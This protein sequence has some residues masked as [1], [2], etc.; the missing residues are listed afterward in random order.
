MHE[1]AS[2]IH[3]I[4]RL[5][6][7]QSI[8]YRDLAES[9]T[10]SE[11]SVKRMMSANRITLDRLSQISEILGYT[12]SE[13]TQEA[14][15]SKARISMLTVEQERLIVSDTKLLLTTVCALNHWKLAEIVETYQLSEAE[16]LQKLLILDRLQILDLLPENRIRLLIARDFEWRKHGPISEFFR[17]HAQPDFLKD[18]FTD[19]DAM[20]F[21]HG[22][23]T[24]TAYSELQPEIDRLR[25][26]FTEFHDRSLPASRQSK[27]SATLLLGIRRKWEPA[28]FQV[29][30]RNAKH[31]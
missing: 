26:K 8:T 20:I 15:T 4:K 6:K 25:T 17:K 16:C 1:I 10:L 28:A 2:I 22:M 5:L 7:Q 24:D 13:L 12:L 27:K 29:L 18:A 31:Q 19:E 3:T 9:L 30:R 11:A 21:I 14:A 23:L